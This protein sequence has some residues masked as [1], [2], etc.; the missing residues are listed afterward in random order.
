MII[1]PTQSRHPFIHRLIDRPTD[2]C[3]RPTTPL[4]P[5]HASL[6]LQTNRFPFLRR[7]SESPGD[8]A[9]QYEGLVAVVKTASVE[10]P[11]QV[12]YGWPNDM[13]GWMAE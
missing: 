11:P 4:T 13:H 5:T 9:V 1:T 3:D 8:P 2:R 6:I 7:M 10:G 12:N